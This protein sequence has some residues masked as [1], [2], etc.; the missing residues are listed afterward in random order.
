MAPVL[1]AVRE[2]M[3]GLQGDDLLGV[4]SAALLAD[5]AALRSLL[6]QGEGEFLRRVGEVHA[7]GAAEAVGAGSTQA[8]LRGTVLMSPLDPSRAV[9]TASVLRSTCPATAAAV[10]AGAIGVGQAHVVAK[11]I[12]ALPSA[13]AQDVAVVLRGPG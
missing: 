1:R 8:F 6:D 13:L 12:E 11:V 2:A 4:D 10:A 7:R 5:V 9:R 3:S